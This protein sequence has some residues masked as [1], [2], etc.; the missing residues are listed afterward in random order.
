MFPRVNRQDRLRS[1]LRDLAKA[2]GQRL[3]PTNPQ[4]LFFSSFGGQYSDSPRAIF[5]TLSDRGRVDATWRASAA[6]AGDFPPHVHSAY[7]STWS[8]ARA[9]ARARYLFTNT[10]LHGNPKTPNTTWVQTWHGTPLKKIAF[11]VARGLSSESVARLTAD[12]AKWD[13]L[14][15]PNP[16]S[17]PI[18]R[19]ALRYE[20][21]IIETGYPRNDVLNSPDRD[22]VRAEVRSR[23][24]IPDGQT[25]ILY[26]PTWRDDLTDSSGVWRFSLPMDAGAM[27]KQLGADFTFM[28]RMHRAVKSADADL[29]HDFARNVTLYPDI[30]DLYLAADV[31]VTDYS[32]VM[33]DFA[34][35][36]K[37]MLFFTHD[38]ETYRDELRGFY[39]DFED[40]APGPL[41]ATTEGLIDALKNLDATGDEYSARYSAFQDKFCCLDDGSAS[42]R[43]IAAVLDGDWSAGG[44]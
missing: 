19:Q 7:P 17:T 23:L 13:Y 14:V 43:V 10:W 1:G 24:Q 37:P 12:I 9:M 40:E 27:A 26:A 44:S 8:H 15:S 31:L 25:A 20:G 42:K 16:F 5:E 39:F 11:D 3:V 36:G 34:I 18:M 2:T 41:L 32:S 33:F 21:E 29:S 6:H 30:A 35:T 28:V 4:S 22:R 38:L